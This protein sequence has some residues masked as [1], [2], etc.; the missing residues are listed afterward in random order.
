[1]ATCRVCMADI[2]WATIE[3]TDDR[4]PIDSHEDAD[5]GPGR[6]RIVLDGQNPVVAAIAEEH[7]LRTHVDHRVLCSQP[8]AI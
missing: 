5:S 1:M 3:G 8:R 7:P 2:R 6:Y 4:V